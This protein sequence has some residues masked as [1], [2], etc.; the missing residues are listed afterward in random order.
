MLRSA[1][2]VEVSARNR[3]TNNGPVEAVGLGQREKSEAVD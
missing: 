3:Y 2:K 1:Q